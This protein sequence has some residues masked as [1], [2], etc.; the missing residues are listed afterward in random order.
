M[1]NAEFK[2]LLHELVKLPT[3]TLFSQVYK[4]SQVS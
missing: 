3:E 2:I 1:Q 4:K